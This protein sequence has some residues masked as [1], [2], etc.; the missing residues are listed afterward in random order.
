MPPRAPIGAP[1]PLSMPGQTASTRLL[2]AAAAAAA[3][4][5]R[6][7]DCADLDAGGLAVLRQHVPVRGPN[8]DFEQLTLHGCICSRDCGECEKA[9]CCQAGHSTKRAS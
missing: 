7:L 9:C 4:H 5:D 2:N 6:A 8:L 3:T 1:R